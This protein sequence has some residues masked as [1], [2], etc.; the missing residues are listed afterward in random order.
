MLLIS[1]EV[2]IGI[3]FGE[4][5]RNVFVNLICCDLKVCRMSLLMRDKGARL[6]RMI[7]E[8]VYEV[9]MI[10]EEGK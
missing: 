9:S 5:P 8:F 10:C 6:G 4:W 3:P 7:K 2:S 1:V